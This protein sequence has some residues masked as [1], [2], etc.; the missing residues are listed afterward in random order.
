MN[1]QEGITRA[2]WRD[3]FDTP[4]MMKAGTVYRVPVDLHATSWYLAA[5]HR[6]RVEISS[7]S[8]PRFDRNLNT[9]GH[10]YDETTCPVAKTSIPHAATPLSRLILPV[11]LRH[12]THPELPPTCPRYARP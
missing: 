7:S 8:F 11:V 3:G 10:T 9:C 1:M 6:L 2:R 12:A 4:H 5:G